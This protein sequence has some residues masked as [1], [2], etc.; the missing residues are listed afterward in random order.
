MTGLLRAEGEARPE[1]DTQYKWDV[2]LRETTD[3]T[4]SK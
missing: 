1:T 3:E 2:P 4:W